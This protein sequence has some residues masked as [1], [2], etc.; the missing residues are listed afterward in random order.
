MIGL[1]DK[2]IIFLKLFIP[3]ILP[4]GWELDLNIVPK[5]KESMY[6]S[7]LYFSNSFFVWIDLE[8]Q[9]APLNFFAF[10]PFNS[11]NDGI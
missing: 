1:L 11:E 10:F 5:T 4:S 6:L 7:L 2:S 3:K 9:E 8:I